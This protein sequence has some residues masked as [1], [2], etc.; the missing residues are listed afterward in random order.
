MK[1]L[2]LTLGFVAIS[3]FSFSQKLKK[4]EKQI[5]ANLQS[6]IGF[7]ADDKLEGRR[8]GTEG[9]KKAMDYI[10]GQ[11]QKIGIQ[12]KGTEGYFQPFEIYDGKTIDPATHLILNGHDLKAGKDFYPLAFSANGSVEAFPA[13]SLKEENTPWFVN[14]ADILE[15][16]EE[17]PHFDL[18]TFLRDMAVDY[19]KMGATAMILY[20]IA[21]KEDNLVFNAKDRSELAPIPIVYITKA[22]ATQYLKDASA[23]IDLKMKV[24][25]G[26]KYRT[27]HNVVGYIDNGAANT[28]VLGAHFDHLGYG[29]DGNS[30]LRT[31]EKLIHNGADDNASGTAAMLEL[32]R[33]LKATKSKTSNYLFIAFSAEELGLNG[34][35]YYTENPTIDLKSVNYMI[36]MDMVGRLNDSTKALTVGG[37]GTSPVWG[38]L[39]NPGTKSYFVIKTDSSGTGPSDHTSFYRKDIPVLFFFTGL[40][41]DYHRPS[42]DADK[43]NYIGEM[44]IIQYIQSIINGVNAEKSK[45]AFT[46]T[47]ETQTT[48]SARFSVSLGVMPDYTYTGAGMRLDGISDGKAA[49]KAGLKAGDIITAIGP[50]S[51]SSVE[52]YMQALGKFKKGDKTTVKYKRGDTSGEVEVQ[53]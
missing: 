52:G 30:M 46:K 15:D 31:S 5:V 42:D 13:I 49:Q 11:F 21:G 4:A 20:N 48:T 25:I 22:T 14:V 29:E 33:L 39:V 47:R 32:A 43:V 17:N 19:K 2:L 41:T 45:L 36:N 38:K 18:V 24:E 9:E 23:S 16:N 10:S 28:V 26:K 27:G 51:V 50:H 44:R 7:L 35:K 3:L 12:P 53:F 40:H 6:H 34:S 1:Q 8:A 37:Y